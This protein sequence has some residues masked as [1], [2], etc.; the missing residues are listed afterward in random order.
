MAIRYII[1][2]ILFINFLLEPILNHFEFKKLKLHPSRRLKYYYMTILGLWLPV[3]LII[4][5]TIFG[6]LTLSEL[7]IKSI[8]FGAYSINKWFSYFIILLSALYF[9]SIVYHMICMKI[10]SQYRVAYNKK[11]DHSHAS[12]NIMDVLLPVTAKEKKYWT[13]VSVS[14]GVCEELLFRGFFIYALRDIFPN[15]SIYIVILITSFVFGIWH[16]YQGRKEILT[17]FLVGIFFCLL[18]ISMDS[19]IPVIL[20]HTFMDWIA[21]D[22]HAEGNQ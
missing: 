21:K 11:V 16:S 17:T 9:I 13:I 22:V 2:I 5:L 18:Y 4:L 8:R 19:L 6:G 1:Y 10:S 14:A 12:K 20:L 3:F 15:L 7:G